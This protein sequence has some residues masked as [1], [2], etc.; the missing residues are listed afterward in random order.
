MGMLAVLG[1]AVH[2]I[3]PQITAMKNSWQVLT[4]MTLWAV[5]MAF[6]AQILSYLGSGYLLQSIL[7]LGHQKVSLWLST[8]I[9]LD[10]TAL[11]W[12][13]EV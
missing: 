3:L 12:L 1:V 11:V 6:I 8:L 5:G 4:S 7:A 9:V 10:R 2:L 13:L